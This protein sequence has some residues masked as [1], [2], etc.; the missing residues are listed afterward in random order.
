MQR[1]SAAIACA[2]WL[3]VAAHERPALHA[4]GAQ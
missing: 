3:I 2:A 1:P 4:A